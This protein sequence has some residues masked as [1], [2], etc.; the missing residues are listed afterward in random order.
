MSSNSDSDVSSSDSEP[1]RG[2]AMKASAHS[3][4]SD[5]ISLSSDDLSSSSSSEDSDFLYEVGQKKDLSMYDS[6]GGLK[7]GDVDDPNSDQMKKLLE[8]R[9]QLG[10]DKDPVFLKEERKRNVEKNRSYNGGGAAGL[11]SSPTRSKSSGK[12][13]AKSTCDGDLKAMQERAEALKSERLKKKE[14]LQ[15]EMSKK[16]DEEVRKKKEKEAR[17]AAQRQKEQ[18]EERKRRD[19]EDDEYFKAKAKREEELLRQK[20]EEEKRRLQAKYAV[21]DSDSDDS[22]QEDLEQI[23]R[24]R[25]A[26]EAKLQREKEEEK[27]RK[28][29]EKEEAR[30][31]KQ[32]AEEEARLAKQR[33]EEEARAAKQRAEE[34]RRRKEEAAILARK[35]QEEEARMAAR[36]RAEEEKRAA[37]R[38]VEQKRREAEKAL[39][40]REEAERNKLLMQGDR[41]DWR[42]EMEENAKKALEKAKANA[43]NEDWTVIQ[44]DDGNG[45]YYCVQQ[46]REKSVNGLDYKNCEEYISPGDCQRLFNVVRALRHLCCSENLPERTQLGMFFILTHSFRFVAVS[47]LSHCSRRKNLWVILGGRSKGSRGRRS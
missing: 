10:M 2:G 23:R 30:L 4:S 19:A 43:G 44:G 41:K 7:E 5:D 15:L 16:H 20:L 6:F 13:R 9:R 38:E 25:E 29:K 40:A 31:A 1:K 35:R 42:K 26:L 11:K 18:E 17:L 21:E 22:D 8:L 27:L 24:E 45:P 46:L 12:G 32:R 14:E 39:R 28:Q 33:A 47:M 37:E 34:E 36:R 3:T